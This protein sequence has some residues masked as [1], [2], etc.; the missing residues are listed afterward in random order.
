[1]SWFRKFSLGKIDTD[2]LEL[3]YEI[4]LLVIAIDEVVSPYVLRVSS[5]ASYGD[6]SR[7]K[8]YYA[9]LRMHSFFLVLKEEYEKCY[10][11][12]ENQKKY[13]FRKTTERIAEKELMRVELKKIKQ[14]LERIKESVDTLE[15]S[16][17]GGREFVALS[18]SIDLLTKEESLFEKLTADDEI[19]VRS[20]I[21][22]ILYDAEKNKKKGIVLVS[23][24]GDRSPILFSNTYSL[25][26]VKYLGLVPV[27]RLK[28]L[29][30][31]S[32]FLNEL[33]EDA[34]LPVP[35]YNL[36]FEGK[37]VHVVPRE[38]SSLLQPLLH[39]A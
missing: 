12:R 13:N 10:S 38:Y 1:M 34:T 19:K 11:L 20:L 2:I 25:V 3:Y 5:L 26:D 21:R 24:F 17:I 35:H 36:L 30:K 9:L 29:E 7:T 33:H 23:Q 6:V 28:G 37:N 27:L 4:E 39:S 16:G 18:K 32:L 8:E 31:R 14:V 15:R 22:R